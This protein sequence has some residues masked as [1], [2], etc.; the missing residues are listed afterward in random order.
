[1]NIF[2]MAFVVN[3]PVGSR[4]LCEMKIA[5]K[6]IWQ[7]FLEPQNLFVAVWDNIFWDNCT[8]LEKFLEFSGEIWCYCSHWNSRDWLWYADLCLKYDVHLWWTNWPIMTF[9][10]KIMPNTWWE[11]TP[12]QISAISISPTTQSTSCD[13]YQS[14][15]I[16]CLSKSHNKYNR[17]ERL[18]II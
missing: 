17:Y 13:T 7:I 15:I 11:G 16:T 2:R 14:I 9:E 4:G 1:M 12:Y 8:H 18:W 5:E 3:K 10:C 6:A